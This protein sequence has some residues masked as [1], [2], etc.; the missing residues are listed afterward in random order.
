MRLALVTGAR[1]DELCALKVSDAHERRDGWWITIREGKT[2]A[3]VRDIPVHESAA[4]VL[5][6]R[7]KGSRGFIFEGLCLVDQT[8]SALGTS[9][10]RLATTPANST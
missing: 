9:P 8:R 1:L 4:H 2:E 3:A 7:C 10:R 6:R 5:I